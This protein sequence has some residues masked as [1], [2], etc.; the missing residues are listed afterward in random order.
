VPISNDLRRNSSLATERIVRDDLIAAAANAEDIAF[1][2]GSGLSGEPKGIYNWVPAAGKANQ[3]GTALAD[4]RTDIRKAKNRLDN[5]NVPNNNRAWFMHS[6]TMNY[7]GWDLVDGNGNFAFPSMQTPASASLGG[8]RV[9]RDNNISIT[10][11]STQSESYYVEMSECFIGDAMELELEVI[12][13]ATYDVSGTLRSGVS[14][15]ESV[16][17]LIRKVDFGMRHVE[18]AFVLEAVTLGS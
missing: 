1:L 10:L 13:N 3:T 12:E 2:K 5:N 9:Y 8:D 14:R 16:I 11:S 17:R 18:A 7:I 15:D 4:I 6:R